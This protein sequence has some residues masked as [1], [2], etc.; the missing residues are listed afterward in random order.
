VKRLLGILFVATL[1]IGGCGRLRLNDAGNSSAAEASLRAALGDTSRPE[2]VTADKE[3]A[4]LWKLTR[5]F[6]TRRSYQPAWIDDKQPTDNMDALIRALEAADHEGLDPQMYNLD[7]LKA[8]REEAAKGF[9][10]KKGFEAEQAARL[11]VFLTYLYM[12]YA[13]DLADG[14]SDL[15]QADPTWRIQPE[16]FNALEHLERALSEHRVADSLGDLAPSAPQYRRLR[17]ALAEYRKKAAEDGWP[18]LPKNFRLKKGETSHNVVLLAQ[19][20]SASGDYS[21]NVPE[22]GAMTFDDSLVD[23]TKKFQRRHGLQ[24][25]GT[26]S[27]AVVAEMNVPIEQRIDQIRLN[28]ERWRWL[29]RNLGDRYIF[30]NVPAYRLEVWERGQVP[31]AMRVVVGKKD[32]PT[33][34]FNDQMT[35]IV[36]SPYWNVPPT[37]AQG[38]TLPSVMRDADFLERNNMEVLDAGGNPVDPSSIDLAEPKQYRF[39]Q[40]PGSGNSLGLVKF[41]FP[42]EFNVYLHDTPAESLFARATRSFSHGC[43]R[44]EEPR[45]LAEYL[46]KGQEGWTEDRIVDAMHAGEEKFVK[47]E[48]PVPVYLGYWT[49][50][51]TEDGIQFNNDVYAIDRRQTMVVADRSMRVRKSVEAAVATTGFKKQNPRKN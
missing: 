13:S 6:Y 19:R 3:G 39:R 36:F 15:A 32:T 8:R 9:L 50:T 18:T 49:A 21:G 27:P 14:I 45:A 41:M 42:N 5:E 26:V 25:D 20:L 33:P 44:I 46:L 23:A 22:N 48:K 11:E 28:L 4:R 17:E 10:I 24:E 35:H 30:V 31:L 37:I 51:P 12:K 43:V 40:R 34:I 47:I 16:Q 38:E 2:F 7:A 29:P 1:T